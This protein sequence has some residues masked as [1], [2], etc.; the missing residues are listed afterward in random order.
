VGLAAD[1]HNRADLGAS[2]IGN[3]AGLGSGIRGTWFGVAVAD[4]AH[5][6]AGA[7]RGPIDQVGG[8]AGEVGQVVTGA[9]GPCHQ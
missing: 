1:A 5:H 6:L 9:V 2:A 8:R 3:P 7:H 4:E